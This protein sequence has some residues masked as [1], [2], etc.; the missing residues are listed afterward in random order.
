MIMGHKL[1][2]EKWPTGE[3]VFFTTTVPF[4]FVVREFIYSEILF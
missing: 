3:L 2:D 1:F 4:V